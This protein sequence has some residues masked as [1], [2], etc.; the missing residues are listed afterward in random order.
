MLDEALNG[1]ARAGY[2]ST[3]QSYGSHVQPP[4]R[5]S[6]T[7]PARSQESMLDEALAGLAKAGFGGASAKPSLPS[8]GTFR[9]VDLAA[10]TPESWQ[11]EL[12]K[13]IMAVG[14]PP[15]KSGLDR[16][17]AQTG[18]PA[19]VVDGGHRA[20]AAP[21]PPVDRGG[22]VRPGSAGR[23]NTAK[24]NTYDSLVAQLEQLQREAM[25]HR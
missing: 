11:Q 3:T 22:P 9:G 20:F 8:L 4:R 16:G 24:E 7:P 14:P 12:D 19:R 25:G 1:L 10:I 13:V 21:A 18:A 2:G 6:P 15:S 5:P 23:S 17:L